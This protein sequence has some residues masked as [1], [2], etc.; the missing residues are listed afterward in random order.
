MIKKSGCECSQLDLDFSK[1]RL[2]TFHNQAII[3]RFNVSCLG[4]YGGVIHRNQ[5]PPL[6]T[7][8]INIIVQG[9]AVFPVF[10]LFAIHNNSFPG[11]IGSSCDDEYVFPFLHS[12]SQIILMH[13]I[14]KVRKGVNRPIFQIR[15]SRGRY[16]KDSARWVGDIEADPARSAMV[17]A[18]FKTR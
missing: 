16:C 13:S 18:N 6:I 11:F 10:D 12:F 3:V 4:K 15:S 5:F 8:F 1:L 17:R 7:H 9:G 2:W 14:A